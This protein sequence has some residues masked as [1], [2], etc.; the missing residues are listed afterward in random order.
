MKN[1]DFDHVIGILSVDVGFDEDNEDYFVYDRE[2]EE[3]F[4]F[5]SQCDMIKYL[6]DRLNA[7]ADLN[8]ELGGD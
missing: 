3:E 4:S 1:R 5:V 6:T 2:T 7:I 8:D